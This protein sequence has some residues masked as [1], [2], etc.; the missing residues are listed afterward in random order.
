LGEGEENKGLCVSQEFF[1]GKI[2]EKF[3]KK[4]RSYGNKKISE[5]F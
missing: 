5:I 1:A 4:F 2:F 3:K